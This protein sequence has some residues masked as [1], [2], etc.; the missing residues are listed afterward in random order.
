MVHKHMHA[1]AC[2]GLHARGYIHM[3]E[4]VAWLHVCMQM[5]QS[6]RPYLVVP[7]VP[8]E[9]VERREV[10]VV[11]RAVRVWK[12]DESIFGSRKKEAEAKD[13]LDNDLVRHRTRG[14]VGHWRGSTIVAAFTSL[15][16]GRGEG[17]S[18]SRNDRHAS[19]RLPISPSGAAHAAFCADACAT[20]Q[21]NSLASRSSEVPAP[22]HANK[23]APRVAR[24]G[25]Q[26]LS[27]QFQLDWS[28]VTCKSRFRKLVARED[29]AV[30]A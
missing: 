15:H 16:S 19:M 18:M 14:P 10:A 28:R 2:A 25:L 23:R 4:G 27:A 9:R 7:N 11:K 17:P 24:C 8:R 22:Y 29:K 1:C 5:L 12:A 6:Q 13:L 21:Q 26:V 20:A 30:S 3:R